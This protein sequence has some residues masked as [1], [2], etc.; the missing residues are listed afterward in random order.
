MSQEAY[1][2]PDGTL[3][4]VVSRDEH[5][6]ITLGFD[7]CAW[8]VHGDLLVS[9]YAH[10][11]VV[12]LTPASASRRF[13]QEV[14]GGRA[15]IVVQRVDGAVRDIWVTGDPSRELRCRQPGESLEFRR[16]DG[17]AIPA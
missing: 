12:G 14:I 11:D 2:S 1:V 9:G 5:G 6:D 4:F 15:I 13:V 8:H 16:W 7:G 3:R 17:T 10:D